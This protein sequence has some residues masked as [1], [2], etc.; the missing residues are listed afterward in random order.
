MRYYKDIQDGYIVAIGT[1]GGGVDALP[2]ADGLFIV[3]V[4]P[5]FAIGHDVT[6][7]GVA[8]GAVVVYVDDAKLL[9]CS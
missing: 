7:Y 8:L 3:L 2:G 1:G 6:I 5:G 4:A 9:G